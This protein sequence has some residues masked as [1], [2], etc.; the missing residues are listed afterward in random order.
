MVGQAGKAGKAG[1][2][3]LAVA[4][5]VSAADPVEAV[6]VRRSDVLPQGTMNSRGIDTCR[7]RQTLLNA[8]TSHS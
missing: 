4:R 6:T 1:K 7:S 3:V 8:T 2:V 5:V